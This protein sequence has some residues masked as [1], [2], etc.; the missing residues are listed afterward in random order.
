MGRKEVL[1]TLKA[2]GSGVWRDFIKSRHI[3]P[4]VV[5][6]STG[7][8]TR[9]IGYLYQ[10]AKGKSIEEAGKFMRLRW[11][12]SRFKKWDRLTDA[13]KMFDGDGIR[14]QITR[15]SKIEPENARRK[16]V[17]RFYEFDFIFTFF[18]VLLSRHNQKC[19]AP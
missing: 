16:K 1:L 7:C 10:R 18:I 17:E 11:L 15:K 5:V 3:K 13:M 4:Q 9:T 14:Y 19:K 8:E 2:S 12:L 6:D